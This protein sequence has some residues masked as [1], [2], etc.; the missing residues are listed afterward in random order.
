MTI[1][2]DT[3]IFLHPKSNTTVRIPKDQVVW[4]EMFFDLNETD[5]G[6]NGSFSQN[7]VFT[8]IGCNLSGLN[9]PR[10]EVGYLN[11]FIRKLGDDDPVNHVLSANWFWTF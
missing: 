7:R 5:W 9:K 1:L 4:D 8:G 2:N 11:Q 3:Y 10:L 6:Q